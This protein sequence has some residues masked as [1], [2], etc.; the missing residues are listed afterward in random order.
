MPLQPPPL[1]PANVAPPV[2]V[3]LRV[4]ELPLVKLALHVPPQSMPD[5]VLLT[6]PLPPPDF[7]TDRRAVVGA[8]VNSAFTVWLEFIATTQAP[9]P[10]HPP[11]FQPVNVDPPA[12]VAVR[13]TELPLTKLAEHELPQEMPLGVLVTVPIPVP[14]F[15]TFKVAVLATALKIAAIV[16][17]VRTVHDPVPEQLPPL[18]P[19]KA[20]PAAAA[21]VSVTVAPASKSSKQSEPQSM[22]GGDELTVP[23]P[24][25]CLLTVTRNGS[26]T[27]MEMGEPE[28]N[29][30]PL[31]L[32]ENSFWF[33]ASKAAR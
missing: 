21:A 13:V 20:D 14:D 3:A 5:G 25:P 31:V 24:A 8:A 28:G 6:V 16:A 29:V 10:L 26:D 30:T 1:Q 32:P 19:P 33:A 27:T 11:P 18:Q 9:V 2:G 7:A 17:V 23:L 22:P 15:V 12:A 4:T